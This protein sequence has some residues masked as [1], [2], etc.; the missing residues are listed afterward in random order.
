MLVGEQVN[1]YLKDLSSLEFVSC[2]GL[3]FVYWYLG[4]WVVLVMRLAGWGGENIFISFFLLDRTVQKAAMTM[5][6]DIIP[7][8]RANGEK[9]FFIENFPAR[10]SSIIYA[11]LYGQEEEE[12]GKKKRL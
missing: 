10:S 1:G 9:S 11:N 5:H 8:K 4:G 2:F 12:P 6:H 3:E 7:I